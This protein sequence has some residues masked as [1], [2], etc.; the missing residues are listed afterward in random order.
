LRK[1]NSSS[2]VPRS[3]KLALDASADRPVPLS[4]VRWIETSQPALLKPVL[5][6]SDGILKLLAQADAASDPAI[7]HAEHLRPM[8]EPFRKR[9]QVALR[10]RI[11]GDWQVC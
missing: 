7:C 4:L 3:S 8:A 2:A 10:N 5:E 1:R 11:R 6:P 9:C